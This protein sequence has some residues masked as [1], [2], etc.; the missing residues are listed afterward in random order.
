MMTTSNTVIYQ[1]AQAERG[2]STGVHG[3]RSAARAA[4]TPVRPQSSLPLLPLGEAA[5]ERLAAGLWDRALRDQAAGEGPREGAERACAT[6]DGGPQSA[7]AL[8]Q[9]A[10]R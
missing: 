1:L 5:G 9:Q 10:K 3:V 6:L 7:T 4:G 2:D 8:L